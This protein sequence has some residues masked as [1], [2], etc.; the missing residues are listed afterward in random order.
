MTT[1]V[2]DKEEVLG[3]G[4]ESLREENATL[5]RMLANKNEENA[6]LRKI[7]DNT[8]EEIAKLK[9]SVVDM[10]Y[11]QKNKEKQLV[12][13]NSKL[14]RAEKIS[15]TRLQNLDKCQAWFDGEKDFL[16]TLDLAQVQWMISKLEDALRKYQDHQECLLD[17]EDFDEKSKQEEWCKTLLCPIGKRLMKY[18]VTARD[19]RVYEAKNIARCLENSGKSPLTKEAIESDL[20]PAYDTKHIIKGI[21]GKLRQKRNQ[22][23]GQS[24]VVM[25]E[26][27][28]KYPLNARLPIPSSAQFSAAP[29]PG[30]P[31]R[32]PL[33]PPDF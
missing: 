10:Q 20:M 12:R 25:T 2:Q 21:L 4:V 28:R 27:M 17:E 3:G 33:S 16:E 15:K 22:E 32:S 13:Q 24:R 6:T 14:Q 19:G 9:Q 26:E 18:P 7:L 8:E 11:Q 31:P 1:L 23:G 5:R 30:S 29:M